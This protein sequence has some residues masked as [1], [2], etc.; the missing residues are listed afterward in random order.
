[1]NVA[2]ERVQHSAAVDHYHRNMS[3]SI[4]LPIS[5]A[6]LQWHDESNEVFSD[7]RTLWENATGCRFSYELV[8]KSVLSSRT[9]QYMTIMTYGDGQNTSNVTMQYIHKL[10]LRVLAGTFL[11]REDFIS[12]N[13]YAQRASPLSWRTKIRADRLD[14]SRCFIELCFHG[15]PRART[16]WP[17]PT[18][19]THTRAGAG[20]DAL[21]CFEPATI[22]SR[23]FCK[24][25]AHIS[26]AHPIYTKLSGCGLLL[27]PKTMMAISRSPEVKCA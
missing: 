24:F 2:S 7:Y 12:G 5:Q 8:E 19:R 20:A 6:F 10:L 9:R 16:Q 3:F 26:K 22:A 4:D 23:V 15:R 25:V 13:V 21:T 17:F 18:R 14:G 27:V 11:L 1:M